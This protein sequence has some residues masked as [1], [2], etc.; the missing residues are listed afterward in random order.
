[1]KLALA[2]LAVEAADVE[3][4]LDRAETAIADAATAGADL[5]ALP[6]LFDVGYFAF[7]VY[8]RFS[9]GLGGERL[10]RLSTA[11]AENDVALLAGS[12]VEDLAETAAETDV[13]TPA[14]E[15]L[16]NTAV[17]FDSNGERQLVYR[18]N[19][20]FGY[21]S[22]ESELLTPGEATPVAELGGFTVGVTTCYDLRFPELYRDLVDTGADLVLVPSAWPYPRVEHWKT[23]PRA[24]A[25][26]NFSY[27]ATINASAE[28]DDATLVGRST[29]YDPWGT[30]VA[31]TDDRPDIVFG[32]ADPDEIA[33]VRED[34][35]A[36]DDR[37][38]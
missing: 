37:R 11:A 33:R 13:E 6:E 12:I 17:L 29:L 4:N 34:F 18:K 32:E 31:T 25:I 5:V 8:D 30:P 7:D 15:G 9:Q 28:F 24:R 26:E 21:D 38:R 22:A 1:M 23:L 16:A 20:L 35:P 2:Q 36:L 14:D 27:V 19:H 3:G 10:E